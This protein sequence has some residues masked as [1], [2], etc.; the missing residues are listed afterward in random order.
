MVIFYCS[1]RMPPK[2]VADKSTKK[3][4]EKSPGF[5]RFV[6]TVAESVQKQLDPSALLAKSVRIRL[7]LAWLICIQRTRKDEQPRECEGASRKRAKLQNTPKLPSPALDLLHAYLGKLTDMGGMLVPA[8]AL[9]MK[10]EQACIV[11][12]AK[13]TAWLSEKLREHVEPQLLKLADAG[14]E[15]GMVTIP[16][17]IFKGIEAFALRVREKRSPAAVTLDALRSDGYETSAEQWNYGNS[18]VPIT[19]LPS[20]YQYEMR[21]VLKWG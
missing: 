15:Q 6:A 3:P 10:S 21:V 19:H 16:P 5:N 1:L 9:Q 17:S 4:P 13:L 2:K 20:T 11:Q 7:I 8:K 18:Y 12:R 14:E